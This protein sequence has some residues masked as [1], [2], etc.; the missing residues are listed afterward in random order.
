MMY[1]VTGIG[2]KSVKVMIA[3]GGSQATC[4]KCNRIGYRGSR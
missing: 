3:M 4:C 2:E 1:R